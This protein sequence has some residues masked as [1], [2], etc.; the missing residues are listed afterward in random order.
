[1]RAWRLL[2]YTSFVAFVLATYH[3]LFAGSDAG[4]TWMLAIYFGAMALVGGLLMYRVLI[5]SEAP[6]SAAEE[7]LDGTGLDSASAS[8]AAF[9]VPPRPPSRQQPIL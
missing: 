6:S 4:A 7:L 8:A 1:M 9:T 2:H 5:M 3:G